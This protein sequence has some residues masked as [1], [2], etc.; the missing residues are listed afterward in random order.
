MST[1]QAVSVRVPKGHSVCPECHGDCFL[2]EAGTIEDGQMWIEVVCPVCKSK[3]YILKPERKRR[4]QA[5]W[6]DTS[7]QQ[8]WRSVRQ[9]K[10][11]T[12]YLLGD[13]LPQSFEPSKEDE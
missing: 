12:H 5:L 10:E 2:R 8:A 11:G 3:G 9:Q 7:S 13:S 1:P 4:R 6:A